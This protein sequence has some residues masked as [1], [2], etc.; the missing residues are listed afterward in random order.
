MQNF[1]GKLFLNLN[2]IL[3]V[4]REE[5]QL[6][7]V[8]QVESVAYALCGDGPVCLPAFTR[9]LRNKVV[10]QLYWNWHKMYNISMLRKACLI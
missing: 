7:F 9:I 1:V 8:E 6:E 2:F 3:F 10:C 4:Y 5:R